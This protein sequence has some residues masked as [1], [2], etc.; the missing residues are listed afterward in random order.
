[1]N[2]EPI[3]PQM[4]FKASLVGNEPVISAACPRSEAWFESMGKHHI[5]PRDLAWVGRMGITV[6]MVSGKV[7]SLRKVLGRDKISSTGLLSCNFDMLD[8]FKTP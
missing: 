2:D 8:P 7:A 5:K 4:L 6:A 1:V 3:K